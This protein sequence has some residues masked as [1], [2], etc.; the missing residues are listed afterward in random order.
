MAHALGEPA[1]AVEV[2]LSNALALAADAGQWATVETLSRELGARRL[3]R[4]APTVPTLEVER[5]KR[6]GQG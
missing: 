6:H 2:A 1:D 4:S 5:A 3:A